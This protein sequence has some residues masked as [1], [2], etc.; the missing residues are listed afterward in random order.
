MCMLLEDQETSS[1]ILYLCALSI[2]ITS[3][4]PPLFIFNT[5]LDFG[6]VLAV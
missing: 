6:T 3:L 1:Q 2:I 4:T 5:L